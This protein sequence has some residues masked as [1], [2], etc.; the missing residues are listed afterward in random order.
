MDK[1]T[2]Q[3]FAYLEKNEHS[4]MELLKNLVSIE[5]PSADREANERIA[6]HLDTYCDALGMEHQIHHF[7]KAG[8]TF[9]AWTRPQEK[10]PI[11]L[12]GHM[13]TVHAVGKFGPEPFLV[14]DDR[15]YGPGVYDMKGGDVIALFVLRALNAVGYEDRQIKLVLTGDEEVA[16]AFSHG[17]A[18]KLVE[19]YASGCEA[20][21][22]LESG[23]TSGEV[24][25]RRNGGAIIR[26]KVKGK[27]AHAG[28]EPQKG[29]SAILQAARMITEIES[30]SVFG[31]LSFNC[32]RISGGT[33]ANVI[34]D[35]CEFSIGIRYAANAQ[36]EEAIAF[37]KNLC[38]HVTVPGTSCT[39]EQNGYYPAMEMVD[40]AD[41]LLSLYQESC[42][43]LG[44]PI[45][46]GIQ[47]SGCSDTSFVTR[48]GIPALCSLGIQGAGKEPQKGAS[49]ILQ[50]ARM[51][52]EIESRSVFGYLSFNCGRISGGTGANV[53]PDSCEF[54]IGIRY[55]AN[56]QY[57]EAIAFLKNLCEH[58][59]VPG[60][61]CTMEQNG[62]YPA[63]EMVD[64]ADRLLSLYQESCKLLG[65]PIPQ[66]IQQSGCSDT[67]FVTRIGIPA[68]CSLGIQGAGAH[69]LDE[70]A[71]PSSL[72]VQCKKL[73]ATILAM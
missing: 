40:G 4:M 37:L 44:E 66:G 17:E 3:A 65:E 60:T 54:S 35:S 26:V 23:Y 62:Y 27:A 9:A 22:N 10:K 29:A 43:L 32:G 2:E 51:I 53:I 11:L 14:K 59:T 8:P 56:A 6:A 58:V 20:A 48:I 16:H 21:F 47:Q 45:P 5:T 13:D 67:S 55:A 19:Q 57:E 15:V 7:E 12:L 71:I 39:M 63:M 41:R 68:L 28:K 24:T 34:P 72:L 73:V 18:G 46:Q 25:T 52:T 50:A 42:K 36:Y 31:Y 49:A 61:S 1:R 38:E 64:G 69:S 33:G 30:R 70:Y